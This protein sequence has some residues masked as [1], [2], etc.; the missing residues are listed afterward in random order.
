MSYDPNRESANPFYLVDKC[1]I[2]ISGISINQPFY[3]HF[4]ALPSS[5]HPASAIYL[6]RN[7]K[8]A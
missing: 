5:L 7:H 2:S 8:S 1:L 3:E 6:V 4:T